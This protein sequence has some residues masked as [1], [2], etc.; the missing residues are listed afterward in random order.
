MRI[1][2]LVGALLT[3]TNCGPVTE[4]DEHGH[5]TEVGSPAHSDELVSVH[6]HARL[7]PSAIALCQCCSCCKEGGGTGGWCFDRCHPP[8]PTY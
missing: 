5:E 7:G 8:P 6:D 2:V 1:I 4:S 3:L